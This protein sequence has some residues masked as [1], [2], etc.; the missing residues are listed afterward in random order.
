MVCTPF[1]S[2]KV[3]IEIHVNDQI[4]VTHLR[5]NNSHWAL[6]LCDLKQTLFYFCFRYKYCMAKA[7]TLWDERI[8]IIAYSQLGLYD[9]VRIMYL[10]LSFQTPVR[11]CIPLKSPF[12]PKVSILIDL[13]Y[14]PHTKPA[15]SDSESWGRTICESDHRSKPFFCFLVLQYFCL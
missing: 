12:T 6:A 7:S 15:C 11:I 8:F 13:E 9:L 5:K 4:I 10:W 3:L 14:I 1:K 2:Y